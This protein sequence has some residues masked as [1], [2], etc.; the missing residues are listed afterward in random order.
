MSKIKIDPKTT[1]ADPK[2]ESLKFN[3]F[4]NLTLPKSDKK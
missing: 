4:A 1:P 3:P 2:A